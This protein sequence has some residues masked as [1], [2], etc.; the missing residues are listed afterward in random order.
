MLQLSLVQYRK[1][2]NIWFTLHVLSERGQFILY[3]KLL[4]MSRLY[5]DL[6]D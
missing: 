3:W 1:Y 2:L 5:F 6:E 4:R